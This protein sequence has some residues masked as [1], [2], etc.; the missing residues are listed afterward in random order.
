MARRD[1]AR[2][3]GW[4]CWWGVTG[5][6]SRCGCEERWWESN[7]CRLTTTGNRGS[8]G[9]RR[10]RIGSRRAAS[11][12]GT[13]RWIIPPRRPRRA[14]RHRLGFH[15]TLAPAVARESQLGPDGHAR[16]GE[17]LPPV[18]L[19]RRLWAGQPRRVPPGAA[20]RRARRTR[21][22]VI[23]VRQRQEQARG[24]HRTAGVR[25]RCGH[26]I[27][28]R[29]LASRIDG[30]AGSSCIA[31]PPPPTA[32]AGER[33]RRSLPGDADMDDATVAA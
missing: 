19:P 20:S 4:S 6:E 8:G 7:S 25:D 12:L 11:R 1:G 24:G 2:D 30:G 32:R 22:R 33:G 9:R 14:T 13:R 23:H 15:W 28:R 3:A 27:Q 29:M 26:T 21:L 18:P 10:R 17:F 31:R 5:R 16:R